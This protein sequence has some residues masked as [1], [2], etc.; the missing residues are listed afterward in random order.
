MTSDLVEILHKMPLRPM[1]T[2]ASVIVRVVNPGGEAA[3]PFRSVKKRLDQ[4]TSV[5][6]AGALEMLLSQCLAGHAPVCYCWLTAT[7]G[8]VAC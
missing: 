8:A 6:Q 2:R 3:C 1:T 4:P 7:H 5:I